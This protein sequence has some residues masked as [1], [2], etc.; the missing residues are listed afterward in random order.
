MLPNIEGVYQNTMYDLK[1]CNPD[2][3]CTL[4]EI[5]KDERFI[6]YVEEIAVEPLSTYLPYIRLERDDD[7]GLNMY[8]NTEVTRSLSDEGYSILRVLLY[9]NTKGELVNKSPISWTA[10][11]GDCTGHIIFLS[12]PASNPSWENMVIDSIL[13]I[14]SMYLDKTEEYK[15]IDDGSGTVRVGKYILFTPHADDV[16]STIASNGP[17]FESTI[18]SLI[19]SEATRKDTF[20][21][22]FNR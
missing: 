18:N 19:G 8:L 15:T 10:V 20:D 6:S 4:L 12:V 2:N 17:R 14:G 16:E 11:D 1:Y 21:T 13:D 5:F 22:Y 3:K 9:V 7:G